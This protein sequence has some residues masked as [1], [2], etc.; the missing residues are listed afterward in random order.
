MRNNYVVVLNRAHVRIY[1]EEQEPGQSKPALR[2]VDAV[3]LPGGRAGYTDR[4]TDEAGRF[5][6]GQ[7]GAPGG[8]IDERLPMQRQEERRAAEDV[9][10]VVNRFFRDRKDETWDLAV[11]APL[12]KAVVERL[13]PGAR[14]RLRK[15]VAKDLVK[16]APAE[17]KAHFNA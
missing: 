7:V 2:E 10:G 9:A 6:K 5:S 11:P 17:L 13:D 15:T 1:S 14:S 12:L 8:G 3:D 16:I 4:E